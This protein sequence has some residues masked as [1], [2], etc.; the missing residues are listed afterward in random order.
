[1]FV[2]KILAID[3]AKFISGFTLE[4]PAGILEKAL[5]LVPRIADMGLDM[6]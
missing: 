1:M 3:P 6:G 5:V 2:E 4:D